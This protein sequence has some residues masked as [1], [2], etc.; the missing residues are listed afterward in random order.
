[1]TT[2]TRVETE[3]ITEDLLQAAHDV[4]EREGPGAMTVRAIAARAGISTMAVYSR[5]GCKAKIL[6]ALYRRGFER[7][8]RELEKV[9]VSPSSVQDI[10]ALGFAYRR[11][12]LDNPGLYGFMFERPLP[13]FDPTLESRQ[14]GLQTT[15]HLLVERVEAFIHESM[16]GVGEPVLVS[17]LIWSALHGEL[18]LELTHS[19]RTPLPGWLV[20][21]PAA[22]EEIYGQVIETVLSGLAIRAQAGGDR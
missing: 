1:M 12:A 10:T 11:F 17:Y 13:G 15:F 22:A 9:P 21:E 4:L 16:G 7:L 8:R 3:R 18:S 5:F 2:T 20:N 14:D 6:E 19:V